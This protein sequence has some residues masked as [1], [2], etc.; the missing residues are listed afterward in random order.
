MTWVAAY[1]NGA[2]GLLSAMPQLVLILAVTVPAAITAAAGAGWPARHLAL[3]ARLVTGAALMAAIGCVAGDLS[4]LVTVLPG[5]RPSVPG[6]GGGLLA[7][8]AAASVIRLIGAGSAG[9][10]VARLRVAGH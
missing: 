9:R 10:R 6:P 4:L 5:L 3:P 7:V 8:A 1:A 2:A